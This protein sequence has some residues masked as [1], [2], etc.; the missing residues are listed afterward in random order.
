MVVVPVV[1]QIVSGLLIIPLESSARI[2]VYKLRQKKPKIFQITLSS[3][4]SIAYFSKGEHTS[5]VE[6][7]PDP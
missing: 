1:V 7:D 6:P 5:V 2:T 4:S 3:P